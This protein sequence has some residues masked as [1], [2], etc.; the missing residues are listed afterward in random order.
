MTKNE[1][2]IGLGLVVVCAVALVGAGVASA[3]L[4][5]GEAH[6]PSS[7]AHSPAA[8]PR[9]STA[10]AELRANRPRTDITNPPKVMPGVQ[11]ARLAEPLPPPSTPREAED[12]WRGE[13]RNKEWSDFMAEY[14]SPLF[15][16]TDGGPHVAHS[17]D[18][19]ES[20]CKVQIDF[21]RPAQLTAANS[22]LA[23]DGYKF[24]Y[25]MDE[26]MTHVDLYVTKLD[27]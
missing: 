3:F 27:K 22:A 23:E 4:S 21:S 17:V 15:N 11:P 7:T 26:Q 19:R 5:G 20:L 25:Q 14:F 9:A 8:P 1:Q 24:T 18:C 13:A 16:P 6:R 2:R 12:R 10:Q